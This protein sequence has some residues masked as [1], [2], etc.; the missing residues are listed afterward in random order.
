MKQL[1]EN[2]LDIAKN[3]VRAGASLITI[4][5]TESTKD[6]TLTI[7]I[8]DDGCGMS[9][10]FLKD[11]TSPFATTRTTRRVGLGIPFLKMEAEMTG[12]AFSIESTVNVGTTVRAT[13]RTDHMDF[14]PLGDLSETMMTLIGGSPDID[15]HLTLARDEKCAEFETRSVRE[16]LE[17]VPLDT[18]DVL[19]WIRENIRDICLSL[20]S[21]NE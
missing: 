5:V 6:H 14:I 21:S 10:S 16:V 7:T 3:S 11:V 1:S 4:D 12:G 18:P 2:I 15:F 19:I 8:G 13:F 9:E 17:G 20:E